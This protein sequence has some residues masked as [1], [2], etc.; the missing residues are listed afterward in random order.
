MQKR[1]LAIDLG[2]SQRF[3]G[4]FGVKSEVTWNRQIGE[5]ILME[6]DTSK[7]DVEFVPTKFWND[8]SSNSNLIHRIQW[9][10]RRYKASDF[11]LSIHGNWGPK[12]AIRGVTTIYMGG[13]LVAK[14][15]ALV[16]SKIYS[17]ETG[18]PLWGTG[19]FDDRRS[20][21]GRLGMVRDTLPFALLI[22]AGFV[23][24]PKDMMVNPLLAAR[25]IAKYYNSF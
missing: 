13:S 6:L 9:I 23:T 12:E 11:L 18:V 14:N 17:K 22:E 15:E 20:R 1:R 10:N 21:F 3:P 16:M 4:A 25:A 19:E 8:V 5:H 7:W 2:H 24:S